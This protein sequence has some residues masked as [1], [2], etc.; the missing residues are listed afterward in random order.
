MKRRAHTYSL[1]GAPR[2]AL[3]VLDTPV[4]ATCCDGRMTLL[5]VNRDGKTRCTLCDFV[6]AKNEDISP[7]EHA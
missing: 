2:A 4:A 7:K 5:V 3:V 6:Y 1:R